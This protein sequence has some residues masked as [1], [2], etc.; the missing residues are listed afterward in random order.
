[1]K[2][3]NE[4]EAK[5]PTKIT[6]AQAKYL[7]HAGNQIDVKVTAHTRDGIVCLHI[8]DFEFE[9]F[10]GALRFLQEASREINH[11]SQNLEVVS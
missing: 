11:T 8:R 3:I 10:E 4:V 5:K 7:K 9:T 2:N 1:M 6:F